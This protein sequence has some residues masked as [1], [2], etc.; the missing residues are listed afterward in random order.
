MGGLFHALPVMLILSILFGLICVMICKATNQMFYA[1][2]MA[3]IFGIVSFLLMTSFS[4]IWVAVFTLIILEV[5]NRFRKKPKT[6]SDQQ[7]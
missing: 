1:R 3:V 7:T 5:Y 4:F 2:I 6:A